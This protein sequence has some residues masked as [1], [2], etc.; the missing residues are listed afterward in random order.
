[1]LGKNHHNNFIITDAQLNKDQTKVWVSTTPSS[2]SI[3][4][5]EIRDGK[6]E[7]TYELNE[8]NPCP[9]LQL[10]LSTD[11]VYIIGT[12]TAGFQLWKAESFGESMTMLRLPNG[13]FNVANPNTINKSNNCVLSAG[14]K[15]GIA[16]IRK[17]LYIWDVETGDLV[18]TLDAH[19]A[20]ILDVQ[21][22]SLG[23]LNAV[24]TSSIDRTVKVWNINYIFEQVHHI[25][26]HEL[27]IDSLNLSTSSGIAITVTIMTNEGG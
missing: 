6:W 16:G 18:K 1:M 27:Q 5:Y 14:N 9:F 11:E 20:R 24:I 3:A 21:P 25:D 22:L 17:N 23:S 15:Y 10:A 12:L 8:L 19:F 13:V 4:M 2:N 26:R 7:T